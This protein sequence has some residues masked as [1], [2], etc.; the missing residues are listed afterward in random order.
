[1]TGHSKRLQAAFASWSHEVYSTN[2]RFVGRC[3]SD[4]A[5]KRS[6]VIARK[7]L[8]NWQK[9]QDRLEGGQ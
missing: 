6:R 3:Y 8:R 4:R 2:R 9:R 7:I 5:R 1:M